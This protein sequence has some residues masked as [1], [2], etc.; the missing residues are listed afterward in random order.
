MKNKS[1]EILKELLGSFANLDYVHPKDIPNI[2]L[3]MDQV[4]QFLEDELNDMRRDEDDK[5]MTKT[6][7]NNYAKAKVLPAPEKKKYSRDHVLMMIFIYYMKNFLS[8]KDISAVLGP[9]TDKYFGGKSQLSFYDVYT[10]LIN[11]EQPQAKALVRDV[12]KKYSASMNSFEDM[13]GEDGDELRNFMFICMLCFDVFIKQKMIQQ[14]IDSAMEK[15]EQTSES[16]E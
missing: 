12:I 13:P 5:I 16:G 15:S 6:M 7:I 3:Y 8:I 4:L 9:I 11:L 14:F 10:E 2:D 1:D